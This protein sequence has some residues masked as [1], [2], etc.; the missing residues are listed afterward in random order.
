MPERPS[1]SDATAAAK[2]LLSVVSESQFAGQLDSAIWLSLVLTDRRAYLRRRQ[3]PA[4]R[5]NREP[6]RHR[7]GDARRFGNDH[8][9]QATSGTDPLATRKLTPSDTKTDPFAQAA[10]RPPVGCRGGCRRAA[11]PRRVGRQCAGRP[12]CWS[13]GRPLWRAPTSSSGP[14]CPPGA[15][16]AGSPPRQSPPTQ[17]RCPNQRISPARSTIRRAIGLPTG[18]GRPQL[19]P[20]APS[21]PGRPSSAPTWRVGPASNPPHTAV[22]GRSAVGRLGVPLKR[23]PGSHQRRRSGPIRSSARPCS[24]PAPPGR[25]ASRLI[26]AAASRPGPPAPGPAA[27]GGRVHARD[28]RR[29]NEGTQGHT[30]EGD[31]RSRLGRERTAPALKCLARLSMAV[32]SFQFFTSEVTHC[33]SKFRTF[34]GTSR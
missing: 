12:R 5:H 16:P 34:D 7:Q 17:P 11:Y 21:Y 18:T 23:L 26:R 9:C 32:F 22:D 29:R 10:G 27:G 31:E 3:R 1:R 25:P 4:V 13:R 6:A 14:R 28:C 20:S 33:P 24:A 8:R 2:K 15:R 30:D 19:S